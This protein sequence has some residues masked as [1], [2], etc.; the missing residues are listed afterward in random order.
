MDWLDMK[1]LKKALKAS[2]DRA[3][4]RL[5]SDEYDSLMDLEQA[6]NDSTNQRPQN[7][8]TTTDSNSNIVTYDGSKLDPITKDS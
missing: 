6:V 2:L 8:M 5:K 7:A 3:L 4:G 1:I